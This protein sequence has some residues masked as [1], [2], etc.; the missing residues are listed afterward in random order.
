M[1]A[2]RMAAA[3]S[4]SCRRV[5]SSTVKPSMTSFISHGDT[6][7]DT[8]AARTASWPS[9]SERRTF[10]R[11]ASSLQGALVIGSDHETDGAVGGAAAGARAGSAAF[12]ST[13]SNSDNVLHAP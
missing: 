6:T 13:A 9:S 11:Y 1:A 7:A 10:N 8:V 3:Y 2:A 5:V 12:P 4:A